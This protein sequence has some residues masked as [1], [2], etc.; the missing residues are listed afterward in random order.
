MR[1]KGEGSVYQQ[2]DGLWAVAIELPSHD[3]SRRRKVI[4]RKQKT[5]VVKE[6]DRLKS[7]LAKHGDIITDSINVET[8]FTYWLDNIAAKRVAPSSLK[9]YRN[10]LLK[11]VTPYLGARKRLDKITPHH[12]RGLEAHYLERGFASAHAAQAFAVVKLSLKDA[13]K[14]GRITTNPADLVAAPRIKKTEQQALTAPEAI[15]VLEHAATDPLGACWAVSIL[16]GARRNEVLGLEVDRVTDHIDFSWQLARLDVDDDGNPVAPA[17]YET[18]P[19][20]GETGPRRYFWTRP[21][22]SRGWRIIPLVDPLKSILERH[23]ASMEPNRYGLMFVTP[24]GKPISPD[25]HSKNWRKLLAQAG[26]DG[27]IVLHGARHT[28]VDLLYAA[29]VP[30]DLIQ[31]IIGHSSRGMTRS[32]KTRGNSERLKAAM[33]QMSAQVT[34]QP[35]DPDAGAVAALVNPKQIE[36]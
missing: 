18:R 28:A 22:S 14:E 24:R 25:Q 4:R 12:L 32:Y 35:V 7:E 27:D 15:T 5:A 26:I 2:K 20:P 29:G 13:L 8:W 30:E 10:Q 21:K 16:T 11:H 17:D 19:L 3:G 9:S 33:Q 36:A 34:R 1:G 31:E 23:I 6:L